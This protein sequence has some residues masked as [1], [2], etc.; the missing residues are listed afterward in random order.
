MCVGLYYLGCAPSYLAL[1]KRQIELYVAQR[2]R[3][4]AAYA[5]REGR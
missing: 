2:V 1:H 5:R 3:Q 4:T